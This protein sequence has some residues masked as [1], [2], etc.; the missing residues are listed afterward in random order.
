[1]CRHFSLVAALLIPQLLAAQE[2]K[3]D[4][5][6]DPLPT[7]AIARLGTVRWRHG[8]GTI[9]VSFLPDGKRLLTIGID[10][11]VRQWDVATGKELKQFQLAGE[12]VGRSDLGQTADNRLRR[13]FL[14]HRLR[15]ALSPDGKFLAVTGTNAWMKLFDT[16]IANVAPNTPQVIYTNVSNIGAT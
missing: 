8:Q 14:D 12:I 15:L 4:A 16:D 10:E 1:M 2:P 6:G 5:Y 11:T 13:I 3:L 7:G 9:F